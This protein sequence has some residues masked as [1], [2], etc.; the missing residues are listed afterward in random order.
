MV[1]TLKARGASVLP[2]T[3]RDIDLLARDAQDKLAAMLRPD[4]TFVA[5]AAR[6]PCK[7]VQMLTENMKIVE[8]MVG[9]LTKSLVSH[10][11]NISSDAVYADSPDPLTEESAYGTDQSSGVMHLARELAFQDVRAP[12]VTLRPSLLYGVADPQTVTGQQISP[13]CQRGKEIVLFGEGEERRD[14]VSIED[15]AELMRRASAAQHGF[16]RHRHRKGPFV[17]GVSP[18]L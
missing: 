17:Q 13:P 2:L 16:S 10:L 1:K 4:D 15:V 5:V 8:S 9:A 11:V 18:N 6:A 7:N 12:F 3:R 14:H